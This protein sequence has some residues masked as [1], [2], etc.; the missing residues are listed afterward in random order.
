MEVTQP[1]GTTNSAQ[2]D[3]DITIYPVDEVTLRKYPLWKHVKVFKL[4][5]SEGGI[6]NQNAFT[7]IML[8][9]RAILE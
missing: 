1:R 9:L 8:S 5:N 3:D 7:V 2:S 4:N 6:K